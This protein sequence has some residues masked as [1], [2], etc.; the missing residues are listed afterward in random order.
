M[1]YKQIIELTPSGVRLE[2][3]NFIEGQIEGSAE[4]RKYTGAE[5]RAV[6]QE[7]RTLADNTIAVAVG[8]DE[9]LNFI[10][11]VGTNY[12]DDAGTIA[13]AISKLDGVLGED[14]MHKD[15]YDP[16]GIEADAFNMDSMTNGNFHK[17]L[18]NT[19]QNIEGVKTF[20]HQPKYAGDPIENE[21]LVNLGYLTDEYGNPTDIMKKSIYDPTSI[22]GDVFDMDNM[23]EGATNKILTNLEQE[24]KGIKTFESFPNLP[25]ENPSQDKQAANKKYVDYAVSGAKTSTSATIASSVA[26][27]GTTPTVSNTDKYIEINLSSVETPSKVT[28][29][30]MAAKVFWEGTMASYQAIGTKDEN[31]IYY[32]YE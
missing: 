7:E 1:A 8:L 10:D 20:I 28:L 3:D 21:D 19:A 17:I 18:T 9:F 32:I 2:D 24:I 26:T 13:D 30:N 15:V 29:G 4:S 11:F 31:T 12:I 6:E 27:T 14:F 22:E 25:D 5:V 23:V 16:R